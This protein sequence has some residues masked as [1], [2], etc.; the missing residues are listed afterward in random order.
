HIYDATFEVVRTEMKRERKGDKVT[1]WEVET[2][3]RDLG[4]RRMRLIPGRTV[5][6]QF[7]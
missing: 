1:E 3:V 7:P 4:V 2:K 6:M 5:Y